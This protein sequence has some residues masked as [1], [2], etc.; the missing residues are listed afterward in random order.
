MFMKNTIL[1]GGILALVMLIAQF[2]THTLD[3]DKP[4]SLTSFLN[5]IGLPQ[6]VL[7]SATGRST[8]NKKVKG[9]ITEDRAYLD[10]NSSFT[11]FGSTAEADKVEVFLLPSDVN[12]NV[13]KELVRQIGRSADISSA[14]SDVIDNK[15]SVKFSNFSPPFP[16]GF[17][18]AYVYAVKNDKATSLLVNDLV[19]IIYPWPT[20][21][22]SADPTTI[23]L[24]DS[25]TV[26]W[27][28][29]NGLRAEYLHVS[30]K[31][32]NATIDDSGE[33]ALNGS[34][35]FVPSTLPAHYLMKVS[36][37]GD[38]FALCSVDIKEHVQASFGAP[39]KSQFYS[40]DPNPS[41]SGTGTP[42][43]SIYLSVV[44]PDQTIAYNGTINI[45]GGG[46]WNHQI[47]SDLNEGDYT[48]YLSDEF[49]RQLDMG[50]LIIKFGPLGVYEGYF[51]DLSAP[52]GLRKFITTDD[53][54]KEA[55]LQNC[56]LNAS[57]NS[58]ENLH[59]TWNGEVIFDN[60]PTN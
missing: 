34:V 42:S 17:Y 23:S 33:V 56:E 25:T 51:Y 52:N 29:T 41:L 58:A 12:G 24:G 44:G 39:I 4:L 27:T 60:H 20:C 13:D 16:F 48:M 50:T 32:S 18:M 49:G 53:I 30:G 2:Q 21:E 7:P 5:S 14:V 36:G 19:T 11:L 1:V 40:S 26:T 46:N 43:R 35:T 8:L 59:C 6:D 57:N 38:S 31:I 47:Q 15:W 9:D 3:D 37:L 54:L 28:T 55:A 10:L 22:I 45:T